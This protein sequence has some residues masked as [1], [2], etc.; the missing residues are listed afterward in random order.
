MLGL[1]LIHVSK[2]GP[3]GQ[4]LIQWQMWKPVQAQLP[5]FCE[6]ARIKVKIKASYVMSVN[7]IT[8]QT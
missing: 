5:A 3:W 1:K 4:H 8:L 2:R 7:T 6:M